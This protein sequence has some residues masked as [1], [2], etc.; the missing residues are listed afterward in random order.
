M[1]ASIRHDWTLAE[2]RALHDLPLFELLDR[3]R[4]VHLEHHPKADVQLCTL[5]SVKTGG[6]PEDCSYCSQSAHHE[7]AV[8][9]EPLLKVDEVLAAARRAKEAG[10]TRFCMGAA[11]REVKDGPQFD[12]VLDMVRGVKSLGLEACVTLGMLKD[13][14]AERLKEAGLDA[15]NHNLDT[16]RQH[17]RSIVT[18]RTYEDRL[19]TL[20]RVR[21][22]GITV[23]SGGIIGMGESVD[24]RCGLLIELAALSPHPESVPVNALARIEG[25]PLAHVPPVDP[26][27]LVRMIAVARILMPKSRVRL[28]AGRTDLSRE[29]QLMCLYAGAN[30]IFYGDKLLTT[31]NPEVEGDEDLIRSAGL[32]VQGAATA[33]E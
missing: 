28:S 16:S 19:S 15:Y 5:L 14:Q 8:K 1:P 13:G 25:T 3:A 22:A 33:A 30:S 29:A 6:C 7:T 18:T 31:P 27:D 2:V 11:W 17:Y 10:A 24:D 32:T 23:C 4:A 9:G 20:R 26:I 21:A 12:R